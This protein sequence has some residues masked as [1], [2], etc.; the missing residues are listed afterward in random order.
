MFG[1]PEASTVEVRARRVESEL[2]G[3]AGIEVNG[4][5]ATADGLSY[6]AIVNYGHF[7][8]MQV[9]GGAVRGLG[10]HLSR[11]D[12]ATRELF[13]TALDGELVR[14]YIRH[15]LRADLL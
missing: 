9:R 1:A 14:A 12:L 6:P 4:G 8:S 13:G 3:I 10:L 5:L 15:A 2:V 7:T 11:L